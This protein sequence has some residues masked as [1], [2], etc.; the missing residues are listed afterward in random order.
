LSNLTH[1]YTL[2]DQGKKIITDK[3]I[4]TVI[5]I[6]DVVTTGATLNECAKTLTTPFPHLKVWG[7]CLA[8]H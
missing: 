5:V 7:C 1:A 8:R 4:T 6:D 3:K 2:T